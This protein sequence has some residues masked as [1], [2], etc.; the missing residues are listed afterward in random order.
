MEPG[1]P[2]DPNLHLVVLM[3]GGAHLYGTATPTSDLDLKGVYVPTA[4]EI[5]LQ[6]IRPTITLGP[7]KAEGVR[8]QAQDVDTELFSL[9]RYLDLL[10]AGQPIALDMLFAP[11]SVMLR[12][13]EPLWSEL[14]SNAHRLVTRRTGAFLR[15][16]RR[17]AAVFGLKGARLAGVRRALELLEAA[18]AR[19]GGTTKLAAIAPE[20]TALTRDVEHITIVSLPT[21]GGDLLQHLDLGGRK[22]PLTASLTRARDL[23]AHVI[24]TYGRRAVE[25][26]RQQGMDW[27]ALS[28]AVRVGHQALELLRTGHIRFPLACAPHLLAIKR[29]ELSY[30]VVAAEIE[31][32]VAE[33]EAAAER[34]PLP[35]EADRAFTDG[36][37]LEAYGAK[38]STWHTRSATRE[39]PP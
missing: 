3:R 19:L 7:A 2:I 14:R 6:R 36:L 24:A 5:L 1:A 23:A 29:G 38:V 18:V 15:Y 39:A 11:D 20:L 17:Q 26:E 22:V 28:H 32:L 31:A 27:K 33:V 25:A 34:S 4:H 13:P 30:N 16:A 10:A 12:A 9:G 8:N 35:E 37:V 21:A